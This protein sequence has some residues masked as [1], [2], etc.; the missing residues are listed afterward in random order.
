MHKESKGNLLPFKTEN[1]HKA[2]HISLV[3]LTVHF[4]VKLDD[5]S[6]F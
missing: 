6:A 5:H 2:K 3:D 1:A 4:L